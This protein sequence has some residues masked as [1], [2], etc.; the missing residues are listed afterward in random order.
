MKTFVLA[1]LLSAVPTVAADIYTFDLLPADGNIAGLPGS[2]VG[3]GYSI[4]NQSASLWLVT[5][6]LDG[7]A[8]QHGTPSSIFD[9]PDIGPGQT[10]TVPF[11]ATTS[12]GLYQLIWDATAP[13]GFVNTGTFLL[14]AEWWDAAPQKGGNPVMS[15]PSA[16]QFYTA[17]VAGPVPEPA[18][19]SVVALAALVFSVLVRRNSS[20]S[21][22]VKLMS[23]RRS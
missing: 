1:V 6:G 11:N 13:A 4:E 5:T 10:V 12:T 9:F 20:V 22:N 8:F 17:T 23:C 16:T 19:I 14:D 15:A 21:R 18:T 2:T 7:G 3:W